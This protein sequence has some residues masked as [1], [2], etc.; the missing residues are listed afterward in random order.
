MTYPKI[1]LQLFKIYVYFLMKNRGYK[2]EYLLQ[3]IG[4]DHNLLKS[5]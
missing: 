4:R 3:F 2:L 1:L 5:N